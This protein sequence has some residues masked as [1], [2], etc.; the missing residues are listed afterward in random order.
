[1]ANYVLENIEG[2]LWNK[3]I[4]HHQVQWLAYRNRNVRL[5]LPGLKPHG[6]KGECDTEEGEWENGESKAQNPSAVV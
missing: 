2:H 6:Q 5:F 1:M 3:S 4:F